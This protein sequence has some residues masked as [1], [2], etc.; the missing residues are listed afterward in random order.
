MGTGQLAGAWIGSHLVLR[1]GARLVRPV[2]VVASLA[3]SLK[4]LTDQMG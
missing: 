4:L 2:L 3:V 1:H